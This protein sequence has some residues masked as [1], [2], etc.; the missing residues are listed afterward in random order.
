MQ[1]LPPYII[2][3][4]CAIAATVFAV[5]EIKRRNKTL[6]AWRLVAVVVAVAALACIALPLKY[7]SERA[8]NTEKKT[9]LLTA[10]FNA[11]SVAADSNTLVYTLDGAIKKAYP[12]ATLLRGL[13]EL[14]EAKANTLHIYGDGLKTYELSQLDSMPVAFHPS[15]KPSGVTSA[16]WAAQLKAGEALQ[17]Q[18]VYNNT[19]TQKVKLVLKGLATGLDSVTV[20]PKSETRFSLSTKPAATG[21]LVY[22]LYADTALKGDIPVQEKPVKPLRVLMLSASPGFETKFLKNWLGSNGYA[23]AMRTAISKNKYNTEFINLPQTNISSLSASML[24]KFDVVIGDLSALTSLNQTETS[25]LKKQV[26]DGGL[27]I[28][29]R[30]DSTDKKSWLQ[31]GF[32]V[33]SPSGKEAAPSFISIDNQKSR[34]GKL[35][36]GNA[37]LIHQNST[38]QLASAGNRT[39]AAA[40]QTGMGKVVFTTLN[41]TYS[42][43]LGGDKEDYAAFWSVL[44]GKAARK[45]DDAPLKISFAS[46]PVVGEPINLNIERGDANALSINNEAVAPEQSLS[47]PFAWVAD[48]QTNT[49]GWQTL[50]NGESFANWYAYPAN[51][52]QSIQSSEK[53][54]ATKVYA[55]SH[56]NTSIVTN[57]IQRNVRIDVP[58]IYFYVLLLAAC[59]FLWIE[60]KRL[61]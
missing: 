31:N 38:Q 45:A 12:K 8:L 55:N 29:V 2:I 46:L 47:V 41:N 1:S 42:W 27:G 26:D 17:V 20:G 6:L 11:D 49:H 60:A 43:M 14:T 5:L 21:L 22:Q 44:I 34:S 40:A 61:I 4:V 13:D 54:N 53:I 52:W 25:V 16:T 48:G 56:P 39:L 3:S 36:T 35:L 58:K 23:V 19:S 28:I 24:N 30:A 9:V 18:G 10:G 51:Q 59:T 32:L 57:S 37:Q 7:D 15:G 33:D 50:Q